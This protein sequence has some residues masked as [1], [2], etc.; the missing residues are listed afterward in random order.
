MPADGIL[1]SAFSNKTGMPIEVRSA[2]STD[3]SVVPTF[4]TTCVLDIDIHR[5]EPKV[6]VHEKAPN[7]EVHERSSRATDALGC[8]LL[9]LISTISTQLYSRAMIQFCSLA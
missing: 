1:D 5:N 7:T 9:F 8:V 2:H 4:V 6:E 3:P